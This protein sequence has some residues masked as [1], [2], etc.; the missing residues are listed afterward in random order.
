MPSLTN[1]LVAEVT[2]FRD[3]AHYRAYLRSL[4]RDHRH[5]GAVATADDYTTFINLLDAL[6]TSV[7]R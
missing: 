1:T 7:E 4:E 6:S 5:N 3:L 2:G